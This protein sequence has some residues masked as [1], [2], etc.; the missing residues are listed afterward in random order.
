MKK[1]CLVLICAHCNDNIVLDQIQNPISNSNGGPI[2]FYEDPPEGWTNFA[3]HDL[4]PE[5]G[6]ILRDVVDKFLNPDEKSFKLDFN[7]ISEGRPGDREV[8][9]K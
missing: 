9:S 8:E 6:D 4:C 5:C 7:F 1:K 3:G 2:K